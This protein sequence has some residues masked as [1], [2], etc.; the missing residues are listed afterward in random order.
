MKFNHQLIIFYELVMVFPVVIDLE[1]I[2]D[3]G[4]M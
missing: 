2:R 3:L 1:G 4:I